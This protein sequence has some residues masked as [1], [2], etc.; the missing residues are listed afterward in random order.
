M[1]YLQ[2]RVGADT[3]NGAVTKT[4]SLYGYTGGTYPI[5][6]AEGKVDECIKSGKDCCG[7]KVNG[8]FEI[9]KNDCDIRKLSCGF[10]IFQS[11]RVKLVE[12]S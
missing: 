12:K 11:H 1:D 8:D 7:I 2:G 3:K 5:C 6:R 4:T 9:V 10:R